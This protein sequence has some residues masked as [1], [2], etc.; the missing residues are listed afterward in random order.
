MSESSPYTYYQKSNRMMTNESENI[1]FS[2]RL[3]LQASLKV[4]LL[5]NLPV[6]RESEDGNKKSIIP[7]GFEN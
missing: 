3:N 5:V 6:G 4:G 2:H 1:Y 7:S